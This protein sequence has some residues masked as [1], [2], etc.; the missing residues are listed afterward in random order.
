MEKCG[1]LGRRLGHSYSPAIHGLLAGYEYRLY[2]KEPEE[3]EEFLKTGDFRGMNVT[4]PYKK[5]V[6]PYCG[7][8]S[9]TAGDRA[10]STRWYGVRTAC[11]QA[12]TPMPLGLSGPFPRW[13]S[14]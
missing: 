2:E 11:W 1:L 9:D 7:E 8:L 3:L 6:I 10:A 12:I 13:V 14:R 4:I 5:A